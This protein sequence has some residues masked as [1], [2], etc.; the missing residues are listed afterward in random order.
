MESW[1]IINSLFYLI[2]AVYLF[3]DIS[4]KGSKYSVITKDVI[5]GARKRQHRSCRVK[6]SAFTQTDRFENMYQSSYIALSCKFR[7]YPGSEQQRRLSDCVDVQAN[8]HLCC[9]HMTKTGSLM[10]PINSLWKNI[11]TRRG[12]SSHPCHPRSRLHSRRKVV[13]EVS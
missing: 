2:C 8:L 9:S 1:Q 6:H 13:F 11:S 4:C 3:K 5:R 12:I 7:Y 10:C